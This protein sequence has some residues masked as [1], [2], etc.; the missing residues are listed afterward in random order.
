MSVRVIGEGNLTADPDLKVLPGGQTVCNLKVAN[1]TSRKN[2]NDEWETIATSYFDIAV[3][4][5]YGENIADTL[6][7][8]DRI[9]F[10]GLMDVQTYERQDGT[11]GQALR[12]TI[13]REGKVSP[14]L[15]FATASVTKAAR[16]DAAPRQ[17]QQRQAA[18]AKKATAP[19]QQRQAA[20]A[21]AVADGGD[22]F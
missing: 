19:R 15:R 3:W 22:D 12:V 18:P 14:N 7:K 16:G 11:E 2:E 9:D 20:P 17:T 5:K 8:G 13:D 21:P 1:N 4:D 6:G 10:S